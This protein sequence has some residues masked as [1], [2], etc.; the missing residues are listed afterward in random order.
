[1][2]ED[3]QKGIIKPLNTT[4]FEA[5]QVEEAFRFMASGRHIGKILLKIREHENDSASLPIV[6]HDR[7]YGKE[8]ES[9]VI[10]G[11]L[12]GFGL[13]LAHH[14]AYRGCKNIVLNSSRGLRTSYQK[15]K[16]K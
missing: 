1:M 8:N 7:I 13:E 6:V 11:G 4:I 5:N 14:L 16:I 15:A 9:I 2:N 10:V 3:L 12:G